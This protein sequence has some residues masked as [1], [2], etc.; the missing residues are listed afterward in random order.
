[1]MELIFRWSSYSVFDLTFSGCYHYTLN[2]DI[3][4]FLTKPKVCKSG[5][6]RYTIILNSIPI[7]LFSSHTLMISNVFFFFFFFIG[8]C[9]Q[10]HF[11]TIMKSSGISNQP[12]LTCSSSY[13]LFCPIPLA[14]CEIG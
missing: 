13:M 8:T 4:R 9:K 1:M 6:T 7:H 10:S 12:R 5:A 11:Y 14:A 2:P 3:H